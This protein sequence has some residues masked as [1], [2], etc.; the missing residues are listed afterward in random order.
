LQRPIKDVVGGFALWCA[1]RQRVT[2][3]G[4][5]F[6]GDPSLE[7]SLNQKSCFSL[8]NL[9]NSSAAR[10][11][12]ARTRSTRQLCGSDFI[13]WTKPTRKASHTKPLQNNLRRYLS[14]IDSAR[15]MIAKRH[16]R[17]CYAGVRLFAQLREY[18]KPFFNCAKRAL[19][20]PQLWGRI[21]G[22]AIAQETVDNSQ[23]IQR[24]RV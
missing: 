18:T 20:I 15:I 13:F 5:G 14:A 8:L 23:Q 12:T 21:D 2:M 7:S 19:K 1:A 16:S 3:S 9:S 24:R 17:A 6:R 10:E 4:S 22:T 11:W